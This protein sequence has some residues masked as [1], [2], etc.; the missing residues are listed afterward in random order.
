M[1]PGEVFIAALVSGLV[2]GFTNDDA[3]DD[4]N[5]VLPGYGKTDRGEALAQKCAALFRKLLLLLKNFLA[6]IAPMGR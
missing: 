2:Y 5:G 3:V 6:V 1:T 4:N